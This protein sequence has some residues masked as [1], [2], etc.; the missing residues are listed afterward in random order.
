MLR[1]H[2]HGAVLLVI[3]FGL[4]GVGVVLAH[5]NKQLAA[6]SRQLSSIISHMDSLESRSTS[7]TNTASPVVSEQVLA[8]P[9]MNEYSFEKHQV[10]DVVA[11]MRVAS[12][13]PAI[14]DQPLS[15]ENVRVK[16]SGN[17]TVSGTYEY[18]MNDV[19]GLEHICFDVE[20]SLERG[21]LPAVEG[22]TVNKRRF[23]FANID[24]AKQVFGPKYVTGKATVQ[25]ADYQLV[26]A[27]TEIT[28]EAEFITLVVKE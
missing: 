2:I 18:D 7:N 9:V 16:F 15:R 21:K 6:V 11:G 3:I 8:M 4:I 10:G 17:A 13:E 14:S 22:D 20:G 27:G 5:Q 23:C 28:D 1:E 26:V 25:I 19:Y 24:E 12:I